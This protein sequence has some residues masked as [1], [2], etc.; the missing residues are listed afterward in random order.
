V[1]IA[2]LSDAAPHPRLWTPE[3]IT[4]GSANKTRLKPGQ[5]KDVPEAEADRMLRTFENTVSVGEP[6]WYLSWK[7]AKAQAAPEPPKKAPKKRATKRGK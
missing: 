5:S 7:E 1:R 2:N 6:D 4:V 3:P